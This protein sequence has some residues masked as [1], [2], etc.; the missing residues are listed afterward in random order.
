MWS[1]A[2]L[3]TRFKLVFCAVFFLLSCERS[4]DKAIVI[5]VGQRVWSFREIQNYFQ[6]RLN[7]S[8]SEKQKPE[9]FKKALLNEIALRSLVE[10]WAREKQIQN[11]KVFL[12]E[13]EKS[14]FSKQKAL[15]RAL[16]DHKSYLSLY[17]FLLEDLAKKGSA[18]SLKQQKNFYSQ[19]KNLF[20]QPPACHLKQILV[21]KK[22]LAY[23]LKKRL[24]QGESFEA[25]SQIHSLKKSPGWV[26]KGD[27]EIF[28]RACFKQT[29]ALSQV[30]K[31]PYGY[32]IFLVG[33]KKPG[34]QKS[35]KQAQKQ[36]L[37]IFREK[38]AKKQ[39]QAWLKKQISKNPVWTNEKL[40]N[41]IRIQ[42]KAQK[43]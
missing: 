27:L 38:I 8:F 13:E 12:T 1:I 30:L 22:R 28:D 5:K 36:I 7:S 10:N 32:H 43:I 14:L 20:I 26:Q 2:L 6:I 35:F 17:N 16:K 39:F 40:L 21:K 9:D 4:K 37:R 29:S 31:S 25:L 24:K 18:P 23:S 33:D 34:K 15:L 19:N 3:L 11:K 41:T 42:Y